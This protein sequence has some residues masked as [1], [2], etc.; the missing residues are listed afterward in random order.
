MIPTMSDDETRAL[1]G[2][3]YD[4]GVRART[5]HLLMSRETVISFA[6]ACAVD[7]PDDWQPT[8]GVGTIMGTSI[9]FVDSMPFGAWEL[10]DIMAGKQL[11]VHAPPA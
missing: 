6:R 11:V 3:T 5:V 1:A 8:P 7:L 9:I 10:H 4:A 2:A